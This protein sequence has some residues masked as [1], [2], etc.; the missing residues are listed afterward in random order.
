L[1]ARERKTLQP[2]TKWALHDPGQGWRAWKVEDKYIPGVP[3]FIVKSPLG[4]VAVIEMKWSSIKTGVRFEASRE[5][6]AHLR[7]WGDRAFMLVASE[8]VDLIVL[9]PASSLEYTDRSMSVKEVKTLLPYTITM[10]FDKQEMR[11]VLRHHLL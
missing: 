5:Q 1:S 3:D 2:W 4:H 9:T 10:R 11:A 6:W 8:A 7:E